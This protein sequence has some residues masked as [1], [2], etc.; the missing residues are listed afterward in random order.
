[1]HKPA[2]I[3]IHRQDQ[4]HCAMGR[5]IRLGALEKANPNTPVIWCS[6]MVVTAKSDGT[7]RRI[8]NIQSQNLHSVLSLIHLAD[9]VS[10]NT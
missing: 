7:P 5:D 4:V 10:Q 9:R 6:V 2:L 8:V 3:P 1:M